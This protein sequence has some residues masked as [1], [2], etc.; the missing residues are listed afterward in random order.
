METVKIEEEKGRGTSGG[1]YFYVVEG[2]TLVHISEY[3]IRTYESKDEVVYE[4][5]KS[6]VAEKVVYCFDFSRKRGA[7]LGKCRIE[8]FEDGRPKKFEY[9]EILEKGIDEIRNLRFQV[10]SY[11]LMYLLT[12]FEDKFIPMI[13]EIKEYEKTLNF[14]ISFRGHQERLKDAFKSPDIYYFTFM[15]LP[16]D[17]R[18]I[19]S[20][21]VTRRW[22]YQIWVL[23]LLCNA[24]RVSKFKGYEY[25]GKPY[26][27]IEQ[28]SEFSTA[29]GETPYG[30][31]TF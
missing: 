19:K 29:I 25:E 18:R 11:K 14:K 5:P 12:Q 31:I 3:A 15:S 22:I 2:N 23:K 6:K 26:W 30:Y 17:D 16:K 21:K 20:L 8:D 9:Y 10:G 27:R 1:P 28:V 24:L 4:V 13:Y 7:L